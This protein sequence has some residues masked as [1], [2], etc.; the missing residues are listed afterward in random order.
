MR[1]VKKWYYKYIKCDIIIQSN[2]NMKGKTTFHF[3]AYAQEFRTHGFAAYYLTLFLTL[4][5]VVVS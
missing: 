4:V 3:Y 2:I 1:C 5:T